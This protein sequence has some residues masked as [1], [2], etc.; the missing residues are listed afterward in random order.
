MCIS[1]YL[2]DIMVRCLGFNWLAEYD[3]HRLGACTRFLQTNTS[4]S[5]SHGLAQ[6]ITI[7]HNLLGEP[8]AWIFSVGMETNVIGCYDIGWH[9]YALCLQVVTGAVAAAV[10]SVTVTDRATVEEPWKEVASVETDKGRTAVGIGE[11]QDALHCM[12]H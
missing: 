9:G 3:C 11:V 12:Y 5:C 1:A 7:V 4:Q 2:H 8:L 6:A 10:T